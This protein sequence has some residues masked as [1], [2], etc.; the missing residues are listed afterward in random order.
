[1]RQKLTSSQRLWM[2]VFGVYGLPRLDEKKVLDIVAQLP[3]RQAQAIRLR[4]GFKGSPITY[5]ELSRVL[6][7]IDGKGSISRETARLEIKR[8]LR[9]LRRPK[10]RPQWETAKK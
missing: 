8:A 4:F 5:E 7:R 9:D 10:W 6:F 2:E 3:Q 1:M